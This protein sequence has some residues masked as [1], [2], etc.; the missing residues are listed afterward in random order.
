[1]FAMMAL[2]TGEVY[3]TFARIPAA[4]DSIDLVCFFSWCDRS[5]CCYLIRG[6]ARAA[7][8]AGLH[9]ASELLLLAALAQVVWASVALLVP[10][11]LFAASAS[12]VSG[13]TAYYA[14]DVI[15][16]LVGCHAHANGAL[17]FHYWIFAMMLPALLVGLIV[18]VR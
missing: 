9:V 11:R 17:P 5:I 3:Y 18:S 6:P 10:L 1:M 15:W 4:L 7:E 2:P 14:D 16:K 12:L 8:A 13:L